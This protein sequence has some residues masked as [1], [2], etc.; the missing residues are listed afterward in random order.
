MSSPVT[1]DPNLYTQVG[2]DS[3]SL[4]MLGTV[5]HSF[6]EQGDYRCVLHRGEETLGV[7]YVKVDM[8]SAAAHVD[9]DLATLSEKGGDDCGCAHHHD[10]AGPHFVVNPRGYAVLHVTKGAGGYSVH[11][12]RADDNPRQKAWDSQELGKGDFFAASILRPGT[13]SVTNG[14]GGGKGEVVVTYPT[15]GKFRNPPPAP[16]R[17]QLTK[18]AIRPNRAKI[19]PGQGLVFE[20][21][22]PSRVKIELLRPDDGPAAAGQIKRAGWRSNRLPAQARRRKKAAG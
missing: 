16:V 9:V 10:E 19:Q 5:V 18:A 17:F 6:T 4:T 14:D 3:G 8:Q 22:V 12:E 20:P 11:V 7:F 15:L 2:L 1:L 13:Y 21:R